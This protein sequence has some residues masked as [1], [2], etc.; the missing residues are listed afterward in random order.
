VSLIAVGRQAS[1][2]TIYRARERCRAHWHHGLLRSQFASMSAFPA[3][4]AFHLRQR[5][6]ALQLEP[7]D[8]S[9]SGCLQRFIAFGEMEPDIPVL[10]F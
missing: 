1:A 7:F 5:P 3:F 4:S 9:F 6:A 2:A 10:F 8:Q